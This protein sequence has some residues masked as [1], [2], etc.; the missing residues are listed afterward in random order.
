MPREYQTIASEN[1]FDIVD[2]RT[3][4]IVG[5]ETDEDMAD[6]IAS[7]MFC[8][9]EAMI[10]HEQTPTVSRV[11]V[12]YRCHGT[13]QIREIQQRDGERIDHYSPCKY[14]SEQQ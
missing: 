9:D 11:G 13:K 6:F 12:C 1:G 10:R 8:D 4:E 7:E 5:F 3:G 2:D 14:C